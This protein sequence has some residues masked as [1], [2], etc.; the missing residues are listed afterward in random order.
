MDGLVNEVEEL[1]KKMKQNKTLISELEKKLTRLAD[2]GDTII[3]F[4]ND[5]NKDPIIENIKKDIE[6]LLPRIKTY[7]PREYLTLYNNYQNL[8]QQYFLL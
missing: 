8:K 2:L 4:H 5:A 1:N 6:S 7:H 3:T